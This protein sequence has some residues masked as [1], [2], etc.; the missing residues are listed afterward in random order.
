MNWIYKER[1]KVKD[2]D[3]ICKENLSAFGN[4]GALDY[5]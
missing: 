3:E 4:K 5:R 2:L 1:A